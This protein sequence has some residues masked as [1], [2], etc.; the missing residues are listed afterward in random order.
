MAPVNSGFYKQKDSS[1]NDL[2]FGHVTSKVL[3]SPFL[4]QKYLFIISVLRSAKLLACM[5]HQITEL[6]GVPSRLGLP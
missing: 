4:G 3:V 1:E 5:V 6:S 2:Q